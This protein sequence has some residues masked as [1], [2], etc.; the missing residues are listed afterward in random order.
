MSGAWA[1]FAANGDPNGGK[2]PTWPKYN[3]STRPT[4]V[5]DESP[6]GPRIENDP[7]SEQR[8]RMLSYGSQQYAAVE[9]GPG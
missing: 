4:L 6:A 8:K 9:T 5:W 1:N 2:T 7:R 3:S